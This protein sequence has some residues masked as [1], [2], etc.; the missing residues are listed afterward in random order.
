[1]PDL[2]KHFATLE[3]TPD[4]F[5]IDWM[6]TLF[7]QVVEMD[8]VSRIWD[9]F[10]LDGEIFALRTA[11]ALLKCRESQLMNQSYY[12]II[13]VLRGGNQRNEAMTEIQSMVKKI[14]EERLFKYIE[15]TE[16]DKDE[17]YSDLKMQ[18][19]SYQK[20]KILGGVFK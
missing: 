16:I 11:L 6:L 15:S 18:K 1:M 19:W 8:I 5:L 10:L 13:K 3:I 17:Y 20:S 9:N 2:A 14:S 4:L 7:S 12:T